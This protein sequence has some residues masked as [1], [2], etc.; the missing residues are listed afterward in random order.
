MAIYRLLQNVA[1]GPEE[2]SRMIAAYE[3][4]LLELDSNK[5]SAAI[6]KTIAKRIIEIAETGERDPLRICALALEGLR[7]AASDVG[8]SELIGDIRGREFVSA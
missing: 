4:A 8:H 5:Q 6:T 1:F 2:I 3:A 7:P